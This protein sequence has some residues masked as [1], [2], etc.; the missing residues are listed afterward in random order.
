MLLPVEKYGKNELE[1]GIRVAQRK[2]MWLLDEL[3]LLLGWIG[4]GKGSLVII[5]KVL[6]GD[7][8]GFCV[9][10]SGLGMSFY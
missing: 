4:A 9:L 5:G 7:L 1:Y 6:H 10:C 8:I 3:S 2:R